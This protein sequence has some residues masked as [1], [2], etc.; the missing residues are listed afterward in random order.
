MTSS[1]IFTNLFEAMTSRSKSQR[2]HF[3]TYQKQWD[4]T[5]NP[6]SSVLS[7]PKASLSSCS[8]NKILMNALQAVKVF[9]LI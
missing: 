2:K 4:P 6:G 5:A 7:K 1:D 3:G 8:S 9:T